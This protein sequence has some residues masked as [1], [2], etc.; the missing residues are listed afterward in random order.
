MNIIF[1]GNCQMVS[2]CYFF[3]LLLRNNNIFWLLYGEEFKQHLG[4]WSNKCKN[5]I[6]DYNLSIEL[7]KNS[8]FIIYQDINPN[9]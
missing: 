5:K 8:D 3:Q 4:S 6:L 7:I 1:I 9:K 2:L